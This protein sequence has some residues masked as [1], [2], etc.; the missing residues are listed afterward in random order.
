[1]ALD[2]HYITDGPLEEYFVSKDSGLP[3]AGGTLTFFRDSSRITPKA[4]F[5]LTGSP[6]NYTYVALPNPITLSSVG[7]VQDAAGDNV[8]IYYYP[9]EVDGVT[10][11]L[12]YVVCKD[13]NGVDQF[14][15]EA[16][17]NPNEGGS[18]NPTG[19]LPVQNQISNPQFSQILIND[20]STLSPSTTVFTVSG[21]NNTF[22]VAPDW[23]LVA[24]CSG[25]D[26]VTVQRVAIA[27]Q[28]EAVTSPPFSLSVTTGISITSCILRQR[29]SANS[30][31]WTSTAAESLFLSGG[32]VAKNLINV[33]TT[34]NMFY[35]ASNGALHNTPVQI[36]SGTVGPS[37]DYTYY[38]GGS[39]Q[40]PLSDDALSGNNGYVDI[41]IQFVPGSSIEI[42]SIQVVPSVNVNAAPALLFDVAS[43][44]RNEALMGDY[45]IPR[46]T[47][48][49]IQSMLTGWD[50]PLNPAQFGASVTANATPSYIWD[51]TI[52]ASSSGNIAVTR[53]A[54]TGGLTLTPASNNQAGYILQYLSGAE[55]KEILYSRL[56][57]N[58]SAY[59]GIG[60]G[61]V[62]V[63][64][65]LYRAPA[66]TAFPVIPA[67]IASIASNGAISGVAA[68]W[69]LIPRSGLDTPRA[70][71]ST[72]SPTIN[73]DIQFTGWEIT[74]GTQLSDTDKFAM[75]VTFTWT[76]ATVIN[77]DSISLNKGDLP[78][79]PAA[80]TASDVL[81]QCQ[82]YYE[83][84]YDYG[85]A[86]GGITGAV[87]SNGCILAQ[88]FNNT[89]SSAANGRSF[90]VQYETKK[91]TPSNFTVY[92][93]DGTKDNVQVVSNSPGGSISNTNVVF[94]SFWTQT[95]NG[96]YGSYFMYSVNSVLKSGVAGGLT[97]V[98]ILFHFV[99]D[100]R[101]GIV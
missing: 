88:Q 24:S 50:F 54:V 41:Y 85:I 25:T 4:V 22:E 74:D 23:T 72:S 96:D 78:T 8:V 91:R 45:Y 64:V 100:S 35:Q 12:Y 10:P 19:S 55:A 29:F 84:S 63:S 2:P 32:I 97:E 21:A 49:T 20:V 3:L 51:Q 11:D 6:P 95:G 87:T 5:Q 26:T 18:I 14:T 61:Q 98:Y 38:T 36:L 52:C 65:Y 62:V 71:L 58:I 70:A 57:S 37:A 77:V 75:L 81:S 30:G 73:N 16:W 9:W 43:S 67:S 1:M 13:S 44:N 7:T 28:V 39:T 82:Q 79:R 83:T 90:S 59:L 92:S 42:T 68:G 34:I 56:S 60:S 89:G 27:G 86:T 80:Q 47:Q 69:T 101:L 76:T 94:A 46:L 66:A 99:A 33:S 17:P 93:V 53:N 48:S 31:L 15:R 40:I